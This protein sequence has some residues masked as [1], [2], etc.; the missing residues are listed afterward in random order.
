[1]GMAGNSHASRVWKEIADYTRMIR[2]EF[3]RGLDFLVRDI[4]YAQGAFL[5]IRKNGCMG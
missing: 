1:M 4:C 3:L 2:I 5:S